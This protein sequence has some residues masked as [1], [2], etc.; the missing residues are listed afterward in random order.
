MQAVKQLESLPNEVLIECF[1]YLNAIDIFNAFDYLNRR[2]SNLIRHIPLHLDVGKVEKS[3]LIQFGIKMLLNSQMKTQIRSLRLSKDKSFD[4]IQTL[5]SFVALNEFSQLQALI[6]YNLDRRV[7]LQISPMFPLLTNLRYVHLEN[8]FLGIDG[9]LGSLSRSTVQ[10]LSITRIPDDLS[11]PHP[12]RA[13]VHL[14]ISSCTVNGLCAFFQLSPKLQRLHIEKMLRSYVRVADLLQLPNDQVVHLK[15]LAIDSFY[16]GFDALEALLQRT[17]NLN[18]LKIRTY[19]DLDMIDARRWRKL[20][21]SSLPLLHVFKFIFTLDITDEDHDIAD[22]F[23]LFQTTLQ[24]HQHHWDIEYVLNKEKGVIYTVPYILRRYEVT[25]NAERYSN[26]SYTNKNAFANVTDLILSIAA[27]SKSDQYRFPNVKSLILTNDC[28]DENQG[29]CF[30]KMK[31]IPCLKTMANLCNLTHLKISGLCR[32]KSSAVIL[33]LMKEALHLSSLELDKTILLLMLKNRELCE[34]LNKTIKQ[35]DL[36]DFE[37]D[38]DLNCEEITKLYQTFSNMEK[39]RCS[40]SDLTGLQLT[41]DQLSKLPY[42][43][44]FSYKTSSWRCGNSWLD[45]HKSELDLYSFTISCEYA[46]FYMDED[47]DDMSYFDRDYDDYD[48][49]DAD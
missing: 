45:G 15:R 22:K 49:D 9:V 28:A 17:P 38:T 3:K 8:S 34:Y 36:T 6:L 4:S 46:R 1:E 18:F 21:R 29:Y 26:Q 24:H 25:S 32:W 13:L 40:I 39:F 30:L 10:T 23:H 14:R 2:F 35:L 27:M 37:I 5:L 47:D 43:K 11:P 16:A 33:Q 7:N 42:M 48:D 20:I 31:H 12:F 19:S 44:T 41:I